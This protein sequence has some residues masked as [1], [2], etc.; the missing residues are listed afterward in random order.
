MTRRKHTSKFKFKVVLEALSERFTI[1]ELGRKYDIH[2]AQITTWKAQFLKNGE[3]V[4]DNKVK[5][6]KTESEEMEERLYRAPLARRKVR[7]R[8]PVPG[9]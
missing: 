3:G 1:Q 7:A 2:P 8:V 9:R 5:D 4:F 6:P